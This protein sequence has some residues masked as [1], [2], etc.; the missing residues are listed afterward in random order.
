MFINDKII[1][2]QKNFQ[3]KFI[4]RR[5]SI[6]YNVTRE[7]VAAT[8]PGS[9]K[10]PKKTDLSPFHQK[11]IDVPYIDDGLDA[12]KLDLVLPNEST[13]KPFPLIV[14]I[15]GGGWLIGDKSHVQTQSVYRLLYAGYAVASINYRLAHEAKFPEPLFDCKAAIR[16]LRA[17]AEKFGVDAKKIGVT[18]NSA[19]GH[20]TAMLC[21][22]NN[23]PEFENLS[24][25][26]PD[27]SS[28][29]D[30]GFIWYGAYDFVNWYEDYVKAYPGRPYDYNVTAEA[31]MLGHPINENLDHVKMASPLQQIDKN[32]VPMFIEYG[33]GDHAIPYPQAESFY[34]KY[35]Q[36]NGDE[37]IS[38]HCF[39]GAEHS[40]AVYKTDENVFRFVEF[41]DKYILGITPRKFF[42]LGT[43][44]E[45]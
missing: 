22:T 40:A 38:I 34:E 13:N 30:A 12:H 14:F 8:I 10:I 2:S 18:G 41:F 42:K 9:E 7:Q 1:Y 11:F 23:K 27:V 33:T 25:N 16:F 36:I 35:K 44:G 4:V 24:T 28:S 20:Y 15:H 17:N 45:Y 39:E 31:Y 6:L 43:L 5:L 29:V 21:T 37:N 19:G 26:N 3:Y 32:A